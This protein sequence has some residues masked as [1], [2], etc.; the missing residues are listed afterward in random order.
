MFTG[1]I[2]GTGTVESLASDG[3]LYTLTLSAPV[4]A[5]ATIG[6]SVA[7]N[8]CCLTVV[9][10]DADC[11]AF[12]LL[13]ETL[14]RTSFRTAAPGTK[15]NLELSLRPADRMGGHFVTGHVD[16]V[17]TV[18]RFEPV[19]ADHVITINIPPAL[20]KYLVPK[21]SIAIDG[22]SL[23]VAEIDD[24][25]STL[26]VWLIPHTVEV[27][28]LHQRKA[29]DPVNLE[30]DLLGKYALRAADLDTTPTTPEPPL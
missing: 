30:F 2:L 14:D 16:T 18:Q 26:T 4:V 3:D 27:T 11:L 25:A 22:I 17:G 7:V 5:E 24:N 12:N 19:G 28:N 21:G 20:R 9:S 29:G 13:R 8:G 1:L 23:T 10:K 6:D 15:V